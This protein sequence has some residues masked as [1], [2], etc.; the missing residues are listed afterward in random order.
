MRPSTVALVLACCLH[1]SANGA[2]PSDCPRGKIL[3]ASSGLQ[4]V[5][6]LPQ[7]LV[8]GPPGRLRTISLYESELATDDFLYAA[9]VDV[10]EGQVWIH[11]Y[12]G[13][14]GARVWFGPIEIPADTLEHCR[15]AKMAIPLGEKIVIFEASTPGSPSR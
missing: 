7:R 4:A 15:P 6:A 5:S 9:V 12:G 3:S 10:Q 11:R 1:H 14:D 13:Y 8:T 2:E